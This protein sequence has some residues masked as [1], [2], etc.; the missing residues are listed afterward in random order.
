LLHGK[1]WNAESNPPDKSVDN[2]MGGPMPVLAD[3]LTKRNGPF[4][5]HGTS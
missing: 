3:W 1:K 2:V 5:N 4:A